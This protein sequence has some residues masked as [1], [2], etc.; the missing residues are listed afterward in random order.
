MIY[1]DLFHV[2]G[3]QYCSEQ[4]LFYKNTRIINIKTKPGE[5]KD[6]N[7]T[8][9]ALYRYRDK[10]VTMAKILEKHNFEVKEK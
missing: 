1:S 7:S 4:T 5:S 2:E 6:Y 8:R 9:R 10:I 3:G